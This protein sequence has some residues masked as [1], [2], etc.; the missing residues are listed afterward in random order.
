MGPHQ[1]QARLTTT[2]V[3]DSGALIALDRGDDRTWAALRP[4]ASG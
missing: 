1:P 3:L 2:L 4:S